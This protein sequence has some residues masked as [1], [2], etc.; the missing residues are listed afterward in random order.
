[1]TNQEITL[2]ILRQE[3][4]IV[5]QELSKMLQHI[6]CRRYQD[7]EVLETLIDRIIDL[8]NFIDHRTDL[9]P[10]YAEPWTTTENDDDE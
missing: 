5:R 8:N 3:L 9:P 2:R 4:S 7:H 6:D 10:V 1:M